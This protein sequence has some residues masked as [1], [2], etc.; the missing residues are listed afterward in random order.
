MDLTELKRQRK[1][2]VN[3][4]PWETTRARI[5]SFLLKKLSPPFNHVTDVGSGDAFVV[6]QLSNQSIAKSYFAVDTGYNAEVTEKLRDTIPEN[7]RL[8]SSVDDPEVRNHPADLVLILDVL[9][10]CENDKMELKNIMNK[11]APNQG[12]RLLITVPAFESLFSSHDKLLGHY[13]RYN[14]QSLISI[15]KDEKMTVIRSGYFFFSLAVVRW[16]QKQLERTRHTKAGKSIDN[17]NH[18]IGPTT[19]ISAILWI[20]FRICYGLSSVGLHLPGLSCYC[21]CQT[22]PS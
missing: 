6:Q 9:E 3:R 11:V 20:D 14:R 12:T 16:I 18:G 17:W 4:H 5:I 7:I 10:H 1:K 13:R 2:D 21:L 15:C 22:S 8:F 19:I